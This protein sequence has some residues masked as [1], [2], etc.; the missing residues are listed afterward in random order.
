MFVRNFLMVRLRSE[1]LRRL[2]RFLHLL[3]ELVDPH[4]FKR[5]HRA[6]FRRRARL[7]NVSAANSRARIVA[8]N[9]IDAL[10]ATSYDRGTMSSPQRTRHLCH[11]DRT[12]SPD[13]PIKSEIEG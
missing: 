12:D 6:C 7:E 11:P 10:I 3:G 13:T 8:Q 4:V 1:V 5:N 9:R 2:E